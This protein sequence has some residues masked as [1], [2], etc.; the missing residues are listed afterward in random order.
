MEM[1]TEMTLMITGHSSSQFSDVAQAFTCLSLPN[2][3][4]TGTRTP[5]SLTETHSVAS[6][7]MVENAASDPSLAVWP[8]VNHLSSL[9]FTWLLWEEGR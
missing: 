7:G 5:I 6:R 3:F 4:P 1:H 8:W 9:G 2:Q